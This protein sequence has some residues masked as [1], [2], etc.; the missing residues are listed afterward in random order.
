LERGDVAGKKNRLERHPNHPDANQS[1]ARKEAHLD[2]NLERDVQ[3]ATTTGLERFRFVHRAL[4]EIS[5]NDIDLSVSFLK[6]RLSAPLLI[7]CMTGGTER[8]GRINRILAELAQRFNLGLGLGSARILLEDAGRLAEFK[9]RPL[10]PDILLLANIGAVQLNKGVAVDDVIRIVD[11][12]EADAIVLHLNPLQ[13][14]LQ[15]GG[16]VDFGGLLARIEQLCQELGRPVIVKEVGFGIGAEDAQRMIAAGVYA[17]DVAGA[18]GTS[19]SQVEHYRLTGPLAAV[20]AVFR[21][22]GI[23]TAEAIQRVRA[24]LPTTPLIAS[25]GIRNGIEAAVALRLG[26]DLVG[27]AG[28]FLRAAAAGRSEAADKAFELIETL[29]R[30]LFSTGSRTLEDL[31]LAPMQHWGTAP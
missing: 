13:E 27:V 12:L 22:W 21:S 17:I 10:A 2:I 24:A 25:G 8:G 3:S 18:G 23:P 11:M 28:P 26:A 31:R 5:L 7:S 1:S 29:R 15:V 16:D 30:V 14:S 4:P 20:A 19:W 9:V 6:R